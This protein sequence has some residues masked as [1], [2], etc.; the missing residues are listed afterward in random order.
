MPVPVTVRLIFAAP[1]AS[2]D[3]MPVPV[4]VCGLFAIVTDAAPNASA[5]AMPDG[6][7]ATT[8]GVTDAAP[9]A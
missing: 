5:L 2:P 7:S 3:A 9:K 4:T 6:D 8:P 1:N